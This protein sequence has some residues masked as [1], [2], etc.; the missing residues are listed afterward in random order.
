MKEKLAE[1]MLEIGEI[2]ELE[3]CLIDVQ[4]NAMNKGERSYYCLSFVKIIFD[5]T[6]KLYE[7]MDE[8]SLT[9]RD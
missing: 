7:S 1:W 4:E 5:K 8:F 2:T 3:R 6:N 9:L